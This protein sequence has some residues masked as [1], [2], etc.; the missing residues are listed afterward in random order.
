MS[1]GSPGMGYEEIAG[2]AVETTYGTAPAFSSTVAHW[3]RP[4]NFSLKQTDTPLALPGPSGSN[5]P[6]RYDATIPRHY[7]GVKSVAGNVTVEGEYDD[8]GRYLMN[9]LAEPV[10]Q[11]DTPEASTYTHTFSLPV[12]AAA[13]DTPQSLTV[14]RLN[15]VEDYQY[16]GC[17]IDVLEIRGNADRIVE[18]S[19][20]IIGQAGGDAESDDADTEG[21][22]A[23]P[24]IEFHDSDWRYSGTVSTASGSLTSQ[25]GGAAAVQ[26]S[27]RV[28]NN[29]RAIP[30]TGV[31]AR[32]I[33]EPIF[34]GERRIMLTVTRDFW[35]DTFFDH[36][37]PSTEPGAYAACAIKM[38]SDENITG[39]TTKYDLDLYIPHGLIM[40]PPTEYGGGA[41]ILPEVINIEAGTDGSEAPLIATLINGTTNANGNT[42]GG[43]QS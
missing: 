3:V 16:T 42:Y 43:S 37:F 5:V 1:I 21:Y 18:V 29:W 41:D 14:A 32:T 23:A 9:A 34:Q 30:A 19:M 13:A 20:D 8:I 6:W 26:W 25:T 11:A 35:D 22:S 33:R 28:Q 40:G 12:D 4:I 7:R 38:T 39:S 17:V 24:F 15:G 36:E 31:G 2:F 10:S 27:L